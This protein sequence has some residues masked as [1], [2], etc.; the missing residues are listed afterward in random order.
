M[1][2]CGR[3]R[4]EGRLGQSDF[5]RRIEGLSVLESNWQEEGELTGY[6]S[7]KSYVTCVRRGYQRGEFASS[8]TLCSLDPFGNRILPYGFNIMSKLH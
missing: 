2:L 1:N 7:L 5:R 4:I 3:G 6:D 8:R